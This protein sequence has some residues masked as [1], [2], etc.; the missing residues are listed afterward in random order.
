MGD[1]ILSFQPY[2][3]YSVF[4]ISVVAAFFLMPRKVFE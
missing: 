2:L 4:I 1:F 3:V